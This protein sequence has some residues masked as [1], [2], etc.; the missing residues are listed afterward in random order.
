MS[1]GTIHVR[2]EKLRAAGIMRGAQVQIDY[3]KLGYGVSTFIGVVL[4][5]PTAYAA[6]LK[7]IEKLPQVTH[8]Y[9]TTGQYSLLVRVISKSV[10]DLHTFLTQELQSIPGVNSTETILIMDTPIERSYLL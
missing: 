4:E 8:A 10:R 6:A 1:S 9:F 7:K 5:K 3:E 2:V